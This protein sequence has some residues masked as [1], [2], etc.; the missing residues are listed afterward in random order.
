MNNSRNNIFP[1]IKEVMGHYEC[2]S[3]V[4]TNFIA[5][6]CSALLEKTSFS[7]YDDPAMIHSNPDN[8]AISKL[9]Y[10]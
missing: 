6:H 2:F 1:L 8:S 3:D 9:R 4:Y 7:S 10:F 5:A